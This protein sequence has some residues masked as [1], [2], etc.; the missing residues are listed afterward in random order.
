[1]RDIWLLAWIL[2]G[3]GFTFRFPFVGILLWEWFSLMNPHQEAFGFSHVVPLNLMIALVTIF[4]WGMSKEPKRIPSHYIIVLL[5]LFLIWT[6]F[7]S[8]F[9]FNPAWSWPYW[10]RTWRVLILGFMIAGMAT[11]KT[12]IDALIWV[13][14]ISLLYYGVKGGV[15]TIET[16]GVY[17]VLGPEGSIIGDN[18]QLALALL[19][20]MPLVEYLRTSVSYK[21]LS[22]L[23]AICMVFNGI[24]I[25]GSYSRGAYIAMAA[26]AVLAL[27][28]ARRKF[29]FLVLLAIAGAAIYHFTP[30]EI[31][32]RAATIQSAE[33]DASFHGRWVAWQVAIKYATD[34]F[35]L[36]AGFYG[37]QLNAIFH[38]YFPA[39]MSHA[40]HSIYFQVL[41]EHG[42]IGL[43]LY[44]ALII[45]S[46]GLCWKIARSPQREETL[47]VRKLAGM[48]QISLFAFLVGGAALSMAYY[49]LFIILICIVPQLALLSQKASTKKV[50]FRAA[51]QPVLNVG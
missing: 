18:N 39:E 51:D 3:L 16:G 49:D 30:Q 41:G 4:S 12:R 25:I 46:F 17:K 45:A 48:I 9:A 43:A 31:M 27:L 13:A 50:A 6:T 36:G 19:M 1:M 14:V 20:T 33:S 7:N 15:F 26:M 24:A 34:H 2:L 35:P 44:L 22:W 28:K 11:N 40:A 47:W 32:D 10:D 8:F 38:Y 42:Y 37:P 5:A 29:V 21:P 23:L